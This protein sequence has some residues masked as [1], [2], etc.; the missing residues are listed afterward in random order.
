MKFTGKGSPIEKSLW[1]LQF[2]QVARVVPEIHGRRP[3]EQCMGRPMR[4]DLRLTDLQ[5]RER[6]ASKL[7]NVKI[8]GDVSDA[9]RRVARELGVSKTDVVIALLNE[10]LDRSAVML[11]GWRAPKITAP[12]PKRVCSVKGCG[13]A[14]VAKGLCSNHYQAARRVV[15]R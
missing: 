1:M 7:M 10:G 11:K 3:D 12:P 9:I 6:S 15:K 2:D 8:P 5:R 13:R 14:Y 4:S